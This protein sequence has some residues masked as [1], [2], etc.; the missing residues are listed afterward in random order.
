MF[1][2]NFT[3]EKLDGYG[4]AVGIEFVNVKINHPYR[5][6]TLKQPT[7]SAVLRVLRWQFYLMIYKPINVAL[8]RKQRRANKLH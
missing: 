1:K 8:N 7:F 5:S 3:K 4:L 6:E 2:A